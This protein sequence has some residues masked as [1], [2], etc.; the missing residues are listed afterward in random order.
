M[1]SVIKW[2][3]NNSPAVNTMMIGVLVVGLASFLNMRRES[4]P[5]FELEIILV[6][7]PYPGAS[8]EEVEEGICQKVEEAVRSID[9]IKKQTSVAQEGSGFLVIE[10]ETHVDVQRTLN[11]VR[12]AIDRIPSMPELAEDPEVEQIT[13][14]E[15]A[16][17]VGV[18]GPS[19]HT[20][21]DELA[22]REVAE[23]VR[24]DLLQLP[25]VTQ[26]NIIG[27]RQYQID[28]EIPEAQLRR[29]GLTL[30]QVAGIVRRENQE[31]PGGSMR[32]DT[33]EMLLRGKNKHLVGTEIAKIPLVTQ[34]DGV[35]LTVGDLGD[36]SDAFE[37][38][39]AFNEIDGQPGMVIAVERTRNEDLLRVV[40]EVKGFVKT[41]DLP[42][43]YSLKT[44]ADTS[45]DVR[46]RMNLL[47]KN[48]LQGLVL[49]FLMLAI[50][51]DLRLSF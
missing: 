18:V 46:D 8:P 17:L 10:L 19:S 1:K 30:Q 14:R 34:P 4:F 50:F 35:V 13:F 38:V 11:E 24:D 7:V 9:G 45:V 37:D 42:A 47:I 2:A 36:V 27:S 26:A 44:W 6:S 16:L 15:T 28:I 5:E 41:A 51:L 3:V 39:A 21:A 31:L 49:V 12:S 32:T 20:V 22:L 23:N 29:Y 25:D 43:G 33:Q 48:G 40:D